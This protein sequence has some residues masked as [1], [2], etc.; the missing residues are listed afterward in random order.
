MQQQEMEIY[1]TNRHNKT[2]LRYKCFGVKFVAQ[3][4][5][6]DLFDIIVKYLNTKQNSPKTYL[7][8]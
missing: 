3:T 2:S 6:R 4:H 5:K 8:E 7:K 1:W